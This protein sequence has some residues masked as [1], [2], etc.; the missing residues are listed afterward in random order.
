MMLNDVHRGIKKNK[1]KRRLGR[2]AGS[3]RGKTA[4]RGGKGQRARHGY[5]ALS[6]FQGGASPL[7]R[8]VPKRGFTNSFALIVGT[9]NVGELEAKF[10]AGDEVNVETLRSKS[11]VKSRHAVLKIL[12]D[13]PLTKNLKVAAHRFSES[14]KEKITQAGGEVVILPPK[15]SVEEKKKKAKASKAARPAKS[16]K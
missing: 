1:R 14:A 7:V 10:S 3:G 9:V 12:G 6:I 4:S 8:R 2:G 13:G 16:A 15:V 11:L 5:N